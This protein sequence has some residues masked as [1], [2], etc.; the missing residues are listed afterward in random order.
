MEAPLSDWL[1]QYHADR[2]AVTEALKTPVLMWTP[3]QASQLQSWANTSV[4][5]VTSQL[6]ASTLVFELA[7]SGRNALAQ[8]VTIGRIENND[9]VL[10]DDSVSRLHAILTEDATG[11]AIT[12]ALSK[13]G[14]WIENE[15]LAPN[16]L[17]RV[18]DRAH[19]RIGEA[20]VE[21]CLARTFLA[22]LADTLGPA[23][24]G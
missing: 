12:D 9:V 1:A 8:G 20:R 11:W 4:S 7:K 23:R 6:G 17:H 22:R 2:A 21:F 24:T 13:N 3:R 15:R 5:S 19:L 18:F 16:R 10:V 14:T